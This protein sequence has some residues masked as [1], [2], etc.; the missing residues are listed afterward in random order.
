M[1]MA[2]DQRY[3]GEGGGG[4]GGV[5]L[6]LVITP[7]FILPV[8]LILTNTKGAYCYN[9]TREHAWCQDFACMCT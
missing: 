5:I 2:Y 1:S 7:A 9:Y 3:R 8:N 4:G 6:V